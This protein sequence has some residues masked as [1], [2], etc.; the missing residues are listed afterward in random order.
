VWMHRRSV[1][2]AWPTTLLGVSHGSHSALRAVH[3]E[4][5]RSRGV[6]IRC[7]LAVLFIRVADA[8]AGRM[9]NAWNHTPR[10]PDPAPHWRL[11]DLA[12]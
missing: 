10:H 5:L 8:D 3:V 6:I 1:L 2:F 9:S 12:L 7:D 4:L 11:A